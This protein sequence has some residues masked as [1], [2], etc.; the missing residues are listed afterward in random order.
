VDEESEMVEKVN[1]HKTS[2]EEKDK[3]NAIQEESSRDQREE[4]IMQMSKQDPFN[5]YCII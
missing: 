4:T 5:I 2:R 3:S 1:V